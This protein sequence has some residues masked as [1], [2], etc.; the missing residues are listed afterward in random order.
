[1]KDVALKAG[2]STATVSYVINGHKKVSDEVRKRVLKAIEELD[3][4]PNRTAQNLARS[5]TKC[6]GLFGSDLATMKTH[7]FF[8]GLMAGI[9]SVT[10]KNNYNL[11]VYP[12][13]KNEN[14]EPC[15]TLD[16]GEPIDGAIII[17]PRVSKEY[18]KKII[19]K[20]ISF[21]LVGRPNEYAELINY[22][23]NDN[24]AIAYNAAKYLISLGHTSI[25]L[26]NGPENYTLS[27]DR[28]E[29][30]KMVLEENGIPF[31]KEMVLNSEFNIADGGEAIKKAVLAG[32]KFKAVLTSS[33]TQ[34]IGAIN[35][36]T[37]LGFK[38]PRDISIVCLGETFL[39]RSYN[40]R[41][42]GIDI[43][44]YEIGRKA[45]EQ[46]L[47]IIDKKLIKPSHTIIPFKLNV[48][49]TTSNGKG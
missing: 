1:M 26:L 29:G 17:N 4:K 5:T 22:V 28:L 13:Q 11:I 7:T 48:R 47:S 32:L 46:V 31:K 40:P 24:V 14:L 16:H 44:E 39:T 10:T 49:D 12:E 35:A 23:D 3:Y 15:I 41:I 8:Y 20:N 36:L 19:E 30:Y 27:I 25:L 21:V 2:V 45:A 6:I 43:M 9:L 42:S 18:L 38:I 34:A 37:E 33:D